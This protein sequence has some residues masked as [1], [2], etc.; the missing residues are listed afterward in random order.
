VTDFGQLG[1]QICPVNFRSPRSEGDWPKPAWG[2]AGVASFSRP[3]RLKP[4]VWPAKADLLLLWPASGP[5]LAD[6]AGLSRPE[7]RL[8]P[9]RLVK[10]DFVEI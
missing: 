10:I 1:H 5:A 4:V 2:P 9:V 3:G 7:S 8:W 6:L